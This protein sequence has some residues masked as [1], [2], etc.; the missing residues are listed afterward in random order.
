MRVFLAGVTGAV[1]R[2]LLPLL[3][4]AGHSVVGLTR[5]PAGAGTIPRA[6]GEAAV[7][8]ALDRAAVVAVVTGARPE[9]IV[10][11]MTG[12]GDSIDLRRHG[13]PGKSRSGSPASAWA[14]RS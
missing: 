11:Q 12:L 7:G 5:S 14:N 1:G 8:D 6:C 10:H 4:A 3:V 9:V 13:R 2:R